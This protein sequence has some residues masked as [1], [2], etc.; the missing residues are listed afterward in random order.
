MAKPYPIRR[1][2]HP[3][4]AGLLCEL[5]LLGVPVAAHPRP[6]RSVSPAQ[7]ETVLLRVTDETGRVVEIPQPVRR[8]VSLAPSMTETL[9][10]L[11]M[12][13]RVVGGRCELHAASLA[14][15]AVSR[16][17]SRSASRRASMAV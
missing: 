11:G 12:G 3:C 15:P 13:D 2:L 7:Q 4:A 5:A 16:S 8:I 17:A 14:A 1:I 6:P 10:A 9:F